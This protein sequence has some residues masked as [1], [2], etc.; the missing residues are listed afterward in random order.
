MAEGEFFPFAEPAAHS[1]PSPAGPS[2]RYLYIL[3][4]LEVLFVISGMKE[5]PGRMQLTGDAGGVPKV[6]MGSRV[7]RADAPLSPL[8]SCPTA[9]EVR[10]GRG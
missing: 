5:H 4:R 2:T 10:L 1:S 7:D 8:R 6:G 3:F 9:L